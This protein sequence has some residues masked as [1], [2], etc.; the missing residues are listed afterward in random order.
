MGGQSQGTK[1]HPI[2][3]IG[4]GMGGSLSRVE[5][6]RIV[7][8]DVM[9]GGARLLERF[10]H[11]PSERIIL[12]APLSAALDRIEQARDR[13]ERVVV[14]ADGDPL[15]FGIGATLLER[16]ARD[17]LHFTPGISAV[18]AACARIGLAW[19]DLPVVSLHGRSDS[20]LVMGA[21][22]SKGR[23]AVY[24]DNE[25]TPVSVARLLI[26]RGV[27]AA[28]VWVLEEL[29]APEERV[30]RF[31][32]AEAVQEE[33]SPL[34][35]VIIEASAA[36]D[37]AP[38]LGRTDVAYEKHEGLITKW[39]ARACALAMLR[40][41]RDG[42]L[43]DVGAG[44]GSVGIEACSLMPL[45]QVF[46]VERDPQR[47]KSI[48][49][50]ICRCGAWQVKAVKGEAPEAFI[51]L[52]DPDR[53]FVGGSLG[54]GTAAL[55]EACRRL[56]P[57]GRIVANTVLLGSLNLAV[58]HFKDLGWVM[59]TTQIQASHSSP[60]AA[61]LHLVADNPVFIIAADKPA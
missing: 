58:G 6:E 53:I 11:L 18:Q 35:L 3:I 36:P 33:F 48:R 59:A 23:A 9:A 41:T 12:S 31:S 1:T 29:G 54:G 28:T 26:E 51:G 43:W 34:N 2:E 24:T 13:G 37:G 61:D 46:A 50:N 21:L 5:M 16:F 8:A 44:C 60:L 32:P 39:P 25:N 49:E 56:K 30:R 45:G 57:G 7:S 20:G 55:A 17:A 15:F 22:A 52:P 40:L 10:A 38:V 27:S 42:V 14:L 47:H 4:L 19:N